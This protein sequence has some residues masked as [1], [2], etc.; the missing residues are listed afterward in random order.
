MDI[1]PNTSLTSRDVTLHTYH[2]W[3]GSSYLFK[4][5]A[6]IVTE[7]NDGIDS[8]WPEEAEQD[9]DYT[10]SIY[11]SGWTFN[12]PYSNNHVNGIYFSGGGIDVSSYNVI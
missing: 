6:F 10:I 1:S 4:E 11:G 7:N 8:I 5:D 3:Y 2:P 12:D 9:G